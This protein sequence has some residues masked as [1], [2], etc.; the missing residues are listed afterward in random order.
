MPAPA[1]ALEAVIGYG[2]ARAAA[3]APGAEMLAA[4]TEAGVLLLRLPDLSTLRFIPLAEGA[5]QVDISSDGQYIAASVFTDVPAKTTLL[6]ADGALV[7]DLPGE[8]PRFSPDGASIAVVELDRA[9][10]RYTTRVFG[11]ADGAELGAVAGNT[12]RFSPDGSLLATNDHEELIISGAGGVE[13]LRQ[14]AYLATFAPDASA[15]VI[16]GPAGIERIP[17]GDGGLDLAARRVISPTG[18]RD[19][20]FDAAG[21]LLAFTEAGLL[22][23]GPLAEGE[24]ELLQAGMAAEIPRFGP[25]ALMVALTEPIG[26]A[27]SPLSLVR[28]EDGQIVYQE[29]V[30]EY[31]GG[32]PTF[33]PD[34][35]MAAVVT[36]AGD[37]RLVDVAQGQVAERHLQG[38]FMA[39]F[40]ADG[41]IAAACRGPQVDRYP[42]TG[43]ETPT[44]RL[45]SASVF[46]L[47]TRGLFFEDD[48]RLV[49]MSE[50]TSFG[51]TMSFGLRHWAPGS[52]AEGARGLINLEGRQ[53]LFASPAL[54]NYADGHTVWAPE[55]NKL[56]IEDDH[57]GIRDLS[58]VEP[59]TAVVLG[60][61]G[62][63]L[64]VGGVEGGVSVI[65]QD[66]AERR[67]G[68]LGQRVS[69]VA[70]SADSALVAGVARDGTIGVWELAGGA[71]LL[72]TSTGVL[73]DASAA[74]RYPERA[75]LAFSPGGEL[76][77]VAGQ[78]GAAAYRVADGAELLS[79][80]GPA[81]DVVFA[82][83]GAHLA[84]V[85]QGRVE[86]WRV[87]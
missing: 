34:G 32:Q 30:F 16:S 10:G 87:Q 47:L 37:L 60:P 8:Q 33:S 71:E 26:D 3:F 64:V 63:L 81:S 27:P 38:Y 61:G 80:A 1:A 36:T 19:I 42:I 58:P 52:F 6:S 74:D 17:M 65:E 45:G 85:H 54:W 51:Y 7:R 73:A 21:R 11:V 43:G 24:P 83:D 76:L 57:A 29:A 22:R 23:W 35:R 44:H 62:A 66:G 15:V 49:M 5:D 39:A 2:Q 50:H 86:I 59:T 78:S 13:L 77:A 53:R 69:A 31:E 28:A 20:A 72:R 48:G 41:T 68:D 25:Q 46:W 18:A 70:L 67:L 40:G 79:L 14:S 4:A 55:S 82:A 12:P 84:I 56:R 9:S 75:R